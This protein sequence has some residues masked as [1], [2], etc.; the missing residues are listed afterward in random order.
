MSKHYFLKVKEVEKE[1]EEA[2]TIHFWHPLNEVIAY[3]PGQFLTLLLPM[4]QR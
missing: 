2:S 4:E 3:R 1:T